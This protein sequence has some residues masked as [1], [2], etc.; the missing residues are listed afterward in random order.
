MGTMGTSPVIQKKASQTQQ[1][2]HWVMDECSMLNCLH[3]AKRA[4]RIWIQ[5]YSK[6]DIN[7]TSRTRTINTGLKYAKQKEK[8]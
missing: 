6:L 8:N 1:T 4:N 7:Q 5:A 3:Y 2:P